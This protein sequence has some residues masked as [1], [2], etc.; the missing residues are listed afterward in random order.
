MT[1]TGKCYILFRNSGQIGVVR[2]Q[3]AL[4]CMSFGSYRAS[5]PPEGL[6]LNSTQLLPDREHTWATP[7]E[8]LCNGSTDTDH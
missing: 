2:K 8:Q 4:P 3:M 5:L 1:G 7:G 6:F